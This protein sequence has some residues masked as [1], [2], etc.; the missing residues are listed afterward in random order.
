VW[1]VRRAGATSENFYSTHY[2]AYCGARNR[3]PTERGSMARARLRKE[4][5]RM[6]RCIEEDF[7]FAGKMEYVRQRVSVPG[8][9]YQF[10]EWKLNRPLDVNCPNNP[11]EHHIE[12]VEE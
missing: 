9:G 11:F 5:D 6:F 1:R 12:L 8:G 3:P 10:T 4:V 7:T 2:G